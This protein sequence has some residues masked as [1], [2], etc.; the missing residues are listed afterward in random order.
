MKIKG[1]FREKKESEVTQW[2]PTLCD[3]M[4]VAH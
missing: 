1:D 2:C 4:Y 3:P